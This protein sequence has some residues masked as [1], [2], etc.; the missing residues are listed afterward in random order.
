MERNAHKKAAPRPHPGPHFGKCR[1]IRPKRRRKPIVIPHTEIAHAAMIPHH[2]GR[3]ARA[4]G[5]RRIAHTTAL[6]TST[7]KYIAIRSG[8]FRVENREASTYI[9]LIGCRVSFL[10]APVFRRLLTEPQR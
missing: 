4:A 6:C 7:T 2:T 3:D 8:T 10:S 1:A 5:L 9:H